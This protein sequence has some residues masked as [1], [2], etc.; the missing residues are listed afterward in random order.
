M[1]RCSA[2]GMLPFVL[3]L[4]VPLAAL[5]ADRFD[6]FRDRDRAQ[7]RLALAALSERDDAVLDAFQVM[8]RRRAPVLR[9]EV[10]NEMRVCGEGKPASGSCSEM[11]P[12]QRALHFG[13]TGSAAS[14]RSRKTFC[15]VKQPYSREHSATCAQHAV[16]RIASRARRSMIASSSPSPNVRGCQSS[17]SSVRIAATCSPSSTHAR[18]RIAEER[19]RRR[20]RLAFVRGQ[21]QARIARGQ[22][23]AEGGPALRATPSRTSGRR[24]GQ[25]RSA[26][27][28]A[29][30]G[31]SSSSCELTDDPAVGQRFAGSS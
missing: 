6:R 8:D 28:R 25:H 3:R 22:H 10:S 13:E 24:P 16:V 12:T 9:G 7:Q 23:R 1:Q 14:P 4:I 18:E 30:A 19:Q 11:H 27:Y 15:A 20:V 21:Q 2:L 26:P 29:G 5:G 31:I 17:P